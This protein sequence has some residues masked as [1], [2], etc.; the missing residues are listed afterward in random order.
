MTSIT[1][2]LI[3]RFNAMITELASQDDRA[4]SIIAVLN[5]A[6]VRAAQQNPALAP[7]LLDAAATYL[8]EAAYELRQTKSDDVSRPEVLQ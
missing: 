8:L 5:A 1:P 7:L 6:T 2:E 3:E 4:L